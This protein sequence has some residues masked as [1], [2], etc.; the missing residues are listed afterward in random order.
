MYLVAALSFAGGAIQALLPFISSPYLTRANIS[1]ALIVCLHLCL[2]F[3]AF[4]TAHPT[5][6]NLHFQT[7]TETAMADLFG[8]ASHTIKPANDTTNALPDLALSL[9]VSSFV[10]VALGR[11]PTDILKDDIQIVKIRKLTETVVQYVH[12]DIELEVSKTCLENL[13]I[14][15]VANIPDLIAQVTRLRNE[16]VKVPDLEHETGIDALYERLRNSRQVWLSDA[17]TSEVYKALNVDKS[18]GAPENC[19]RICAIVAEVYWELSIANISL[20]FA[21]AKI[22]DRDSELRK[23]KDKV[24]RL[25]QMC[26]ELINDSRKQACCCAC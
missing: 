13:G 20:A 16:Q 14:Q 2:D 4:L 25:N 26:A 15:S 22:V 21:H 8:P 19:R 1:Q 11:T 23:E 24:T 10:H 6:H 17:Q 18:E 7:A 12:R 5:H 9:A 3:A